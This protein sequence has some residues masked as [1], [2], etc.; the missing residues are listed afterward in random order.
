MVKVVLK[1]VFRRKERL[2]SVKW[3][4]IFRLKRVVRGRRKVMI[5]NWSW[6]VG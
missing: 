4:L 1:K 5:K 2:R 3:R 6:I